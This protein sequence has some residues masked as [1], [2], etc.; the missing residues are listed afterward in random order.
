VYVADESAHRI[1]KFDERGRVQATWG[2]PG[3][4]AGQF[5]KPR[6]LA[7]DASGRIYV[8]DFG[9]YRVQVLDD[10]GRFLRAFGLRLY[11]YPTLVT[12]GE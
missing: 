4:D 9:N 7:Q 3:I 12:S 6:G 10:A 2:E 5:C 11:V 8:V 1:L